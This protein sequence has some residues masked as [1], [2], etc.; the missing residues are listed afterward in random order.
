[1]ESSSL[2]DGG[3]VRLQA[4]GTSRDSQSVSHELQLMER[5]STVFNFLKKKY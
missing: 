3:H 5:G 2:Q 1:M 4:P